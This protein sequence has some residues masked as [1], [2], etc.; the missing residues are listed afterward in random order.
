MSRV[1]FEDIKQADKWIKDKAIQGGKDYHGFYTNDK[2]LILVP[3]KSTR[4]VVYGYVKF[5]KKDDL[6]QYAKSID[7]YPCNKYEW[8]AE[9]G[10]YKE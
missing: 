1:E 10:L 9:R 5:V 8:N 7:I 3:G 6:E 4:P 2:E